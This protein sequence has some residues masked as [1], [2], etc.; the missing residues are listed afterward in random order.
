MGREDWKNCQICGCPLKVDYWKIRA[1]VDDRILKVCNSCKNLY[2]KS[3]GATI[4]KGD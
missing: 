4:V 1:A 2:T 3:Y